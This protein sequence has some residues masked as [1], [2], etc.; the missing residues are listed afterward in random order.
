MSQ[1]N[2]LFVLSSLFKPLADKPVLVIQLDA[3]AAARI[4]NDMVIA[5]QGI[6]ME[7]QQSLTQQKC[8]WSD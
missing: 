4:N 3:L 5:I 1:F 6:D 8:T 7:E 2:G